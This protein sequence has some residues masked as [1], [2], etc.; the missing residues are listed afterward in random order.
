M[1][2]SLTR[3]EQTIANAIARVAEEHARNNAGARVAIEALTRSL[4]DAL[5]NRAAFDRST[6]NVL[7]HAFGW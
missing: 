3:K 1:P 5:A 4:G 2:Y 6:F 7:S